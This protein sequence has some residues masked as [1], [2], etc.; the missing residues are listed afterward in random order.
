MLAGFVEASA[1]NVNEKELFNTGWKFHKGDLNDAQ[2]VT[3]NDA[4]WRKL[5]LPHDWSIEE[6]FSEKWA[7]ATAYLPGGIGWYR[8]TFT[9]SAVQAGKRL[10]I[11]FDG[12]YM[13][14]D[15]WINGHHLGKRPNGFT[16]FEY[17]ITPFVNKS[18]P[19]VIAVKADHSEFA[20]SRWYTGSGIYRN[21]YLKVKNDVHFK[22]WGVGFSTPVVGKDKAEGKVN[23]AIANN[24][25]AKASVTVKASLI[26]A[27][28]KVVGQKSN[29]VTIAAKDSADTG[30]DFVVN[31]P[32][33]W[34]VNKPELYT[35]TVSLW[36]NG[37]KTDEWKDEVGIRKIEFDADK[38]FFLNDEN[39]KLK[40]V[41]IHDDAG[42][43]GVAV[44]PEVWVR[45]LRKLKAGGTNSIR[46]SHNPHADYLYKLC[47]KMGFLVMD[48]AFDEWEYGKN[49]W[50]EGWNVGKPAN[51]GYHTY[52]KEWAE[53]DVR[54]MVQ[55]SRNHPSIIMWSIGNEI[56]YPNDPYTHP[57]L[58]SGRNPQIYGKGY[59]P[60]HPP[61]SRL[62]ELSKK[63]ANAVKSVDKSR[64]VTAALAGVVMSNTTDYPDNLDLVGYNYQ[65]YRYKDDHAKYPK[66][67]IYGSENGMAISAW[68]AVD[69]NQYISAQYLWTGIDYLGEAGKWPWRSNEA[70]LLDMAGFEKASYYLRKALWTNEPV[71]YL[72]SFD[73]TA[74][75]RAVKNP[76][77]TNRSWNWPAGSKIK[78]RCYTNCDEA[79]LILNGKSLGKQAVKNDHTLFFDAFD[80]EPGELLVKGYKNGK[81]ICTDKLLTAGPV[82]AIK[83]NI[84]HDALIAKQTAYQQIEVNITDA[85]G[86]L[87][88]NADGLLN[89]KTNKD[90][91]IMGIENGDATSH[92]SFTAAEHKVRNGSL[93]IYLKK[94]N[95]LTAVGIVL[96]YPGAAPVTVKL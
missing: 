19:N 67:F 11:Y 63:L 10:Y 23:V 36:Q 47:D 31:N 42:A 20:D 38:G 55:R 56:D 12:V 54:D 52:F 26:D 24:Q 6:P 37:K 8:K 14:S 86:I 69:S 16:P 61:V 90:A 76:R 5:T 95:P 43:L 79:E 75:E 58:D 77:A 65:E 30:L 17:D 2:N 72:D 7:S 85:K 33:L 57:V 94:L 88:N 64:P 4:G 34:S 92:D 46:M 22:L 83:T 49:K 84:Y 32:R 45:R 74:N 29:T 13:N 78:I 60:E 40:G 18:K 73:G 71:I 82:A 53:R 28:G 66:R 51:F 62:G 27:A 50:V 39:L 15:V 91:V 3:Y 35:L 21:V 96:T 68:N 41:C 87:V 48:E 81:E 25:N 70:G 80:Y 44:P 89:V 59:M 93:I 9:L 1:Q